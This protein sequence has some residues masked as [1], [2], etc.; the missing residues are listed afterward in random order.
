MTT[1][2]GSLIH[3]IAKGETL[4]EVAR[5]EAGIGRRRVL[6]LRGVGRQ[7]GFGIGGQSVIVRQ[8]ILRAN[9]LKNLLIDVQFGAGIG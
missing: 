6:V 3:L 9:V 2:H 7:G 4:G 1:T 5:I 8:A